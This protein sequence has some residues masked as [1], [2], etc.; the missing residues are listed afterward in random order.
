MNKTIPSDGKQ[1]RESQNYVPTGP[2]FQVCYKLKCSEAEAC[3]IAKRYGK[4]VGNID[5]G[6]K[7]IKS[8]HDWRLD[9][10]REENKAEIRRLTK[11]KGF[12]EKKKLPW[13]WCA[14]IY[15]VSDERG[16]NSLFDKLRPYAAW[17]SNYFASNGLPTPKEPVETQCKKLTNR[18]PI[19]KKLGP[20]ERRILKSKQKLE[21]A[22]AVAVE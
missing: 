8:Y 18:P 1:R 15:V 13:G 4:I 7:T 10:L 16:H 11:N 5:D 3:A 12:G 6:V 14:R 17:D 9:H 22:K 20:K 21:A 19:T 2:L